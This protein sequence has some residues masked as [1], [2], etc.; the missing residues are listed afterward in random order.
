MFKEG[1]HIAYLVLGYGLFQLL[2]AAFFGADMFVSDQLNKTLYFTMLFIISIVSE[3]AIVIL[4]LKGFKKYEYQLLAFALSF[5]ISALITG[6]ILYTF[7]A[8]HRTPAKECLG[9][10]VRF[11]SQKQISLDH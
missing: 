8:W 5:S 9:L 7:F 10:E 3:F 11:L 6:F 2:C 1:K 4:A